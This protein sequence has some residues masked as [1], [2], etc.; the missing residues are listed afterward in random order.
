LAKNKQMTV[1]RRARAAAAGPL[2]ERGR[3]PVRLVLAHAF[4]LAT[5]RVLKYGGGS[6]RLVGSLFDK[7]PYASMIISLNSVPSLDGLIVQLV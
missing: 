4:K 7:A 1:T 3:V 5:S 6:G 2:R